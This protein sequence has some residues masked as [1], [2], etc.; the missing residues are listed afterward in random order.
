[1]LYCHKC[2]AENHNSATHCVDCGADLQSVRVIFCN[3]CLAE[4][5]R[6]ATHCIDCGADLQVVR[7]KF[8]E[9]LRERSLIVNRGVFGL[10]GGAVASAFYGL[11]CAVLVPDIFL[12]KLAFYTGLLIVFVV[13]RYCGHL[14][15]DAINDT[16]LA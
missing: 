11:G 3:A 12:H 10:V 5:Y 13:A 1:M 15:A 14:L 2:P 4:N 9:E 8:S 6:S 16:S 7:K